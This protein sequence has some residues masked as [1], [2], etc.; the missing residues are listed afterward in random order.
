[1]HISI[2]TEKQT[3]N[4]KKWLWNAFSNSDIRHYHWV[5]CQLHPP[6]MVGYWLHSSVSTGGSS[7]WLLGILVKT[8]T[9]QKAMPR[10]AH[11]FKGLASH[12]FGQNRHAW[13]SP[14][15]WPHASFHNGKQ[16]GLPPKQPGIS[17]WMWYLKMLCINVVLVVTHKGC[18]SCFSHCHSK[19]L[20]SFWLLLIYNRRLFWVMS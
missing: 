4:W 17:L 8:P 13:G 10:M 11:Q 12:Y 14:P 19:L 2:E 16:K 1:M 5:S 7:G 18:Y 20:W 6:R 3:R 9:L 15:K